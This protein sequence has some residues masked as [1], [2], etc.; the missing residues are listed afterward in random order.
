MPE[1]NKEEL[2]T[3]KLATDMLITWM[4]IELIGCGYPIRCSEDVKGL[5]Y[6][7]AQAEIS[8]V[9]MDKIKIAELC[10]AIDVFIQ[11]FIERRDK[12]I[13]I[14]L[15]LALALQSAAQDTL[16]EISGESH[17]GILPN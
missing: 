14:A 3:D 1:I 11:K 17:L 5:Q 2:A 4:T 15:A 7:V 6:A 16:A 12:T 9:T 10:K 13:R 8:V